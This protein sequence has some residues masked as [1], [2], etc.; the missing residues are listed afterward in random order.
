[1][2]AA[3]PPYVVVGKILRPHGIRGELRMRI[4][5]DSPGQLADL[6]Y[7]TL[8]DS[9]QS[10][11]G[12]AQPLLGLR[13]HKNYALLKLE[14]CSDRSAAEAYRGKYVLIKRE[15]ALPLAD[16][17]YYLFQLIGLTARA[18]GEALG[19]ITEVIETGA[20]DVYVVDGGAYGELLLPAHDGTIDEID[21]AAQEVRMTLPEG[22]LP[23]P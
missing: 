16:G 17:Q 18:D 9:P 10:R 2:P 12:D 19:K 20:N 5:T 22:L 6:E 15:Q 7:I 21:F 8:A 4:L 11:Q 23:A 3:L 1:M 14:G 13:F